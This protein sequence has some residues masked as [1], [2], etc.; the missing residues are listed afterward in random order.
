MSKE[1]AILNNN[2][3]YNEELLDSFDLDELEEKLQSELETEL[4]DVD[5]LESEKEKIENPDHLGET[6]KNVVW[7]QFLNQVAVTAGE[8][9]IK[10]NQGLTL[11]LSKDAHIQTTDNFANGKIATHNTKIDYQKRYDDWQNNF[12]KDENG[13][14][15]T[16]TDRRTGEEK[17]TLKK[18]ARADFDKGRP[19]G[20]KT[21][22]TNMDHV[23]P[24]ARI[25]RDPEAAAHLSREEQVAYANSEKNLNLMDSAANQSKGDSTMS[26]WLDSERTGK[27][28]GQTQ[29]E[30]FGLNE[31]ELREKERVSEEEYKNTK[32]KGIERSIETGKQSR[33]EEA[34]RI[35]GTAARAV[36]MQLLAELM[37][38][39]IAKLVKWFKSSGKKLETLITSLKEAI[40]SFVSKLKTHLINAADTMV[41]TIATAIFG[42][43]VRMIKK[44][45]ILLKQGCKALKE[46]IAYIKNPEN[47]G[48]P[49]G[50]LILEVG[51]I[52]IAGLSAAGAIVLGEVIEKA[53]VLIPGIG[54]F[55]AA[56]IPLLGS[57]ANILGIF[58]GAVTAGIIGAIAINSI[59][60]SI[61][62]RKK[63]EIRTTIV[64]K[65]NEILQKQNQ[66]IDV[67]QVQLESQKM[68]IAESITQR[69]NK[70]S[71]IMRDAVQNIFS[72]EETDTLDLKSDN[73][74]TFNE[75]E[76]SQKQC[77]D[78]LNN[79]NN[80]LDELL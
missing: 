26:E 45:W 17:S 49:V 33:R 38:E 2:D 53:L 58:L 19:T 4:S 54:A 79:M 23:N 27:G 48:K 20:E 65:G 7:E 59:E 28:A 21:K 12:Q 76:E 61:A 80:L 51:K 62:K 68:H 30:Y 77:D 41:T 56:E 72:D 10:E 57:L 14:I 18:G 24:A 78:M 63:A 16:H 29:A 8:D 37:K 69:H 55:F 46:A 74:E 47:K 39:I 35:G 42:P 5:F 32:E 44:V 71:A 11:D 25:I 34:K 36:I 43:V 6:I 22:N 40:T 3:E 70:A 31:S 60:K 67:K 75:I 15:I 52:V 66:L 73:E 1:N 50:T 13:K 9:F 64:D